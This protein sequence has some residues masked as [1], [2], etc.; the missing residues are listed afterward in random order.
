M[1]WFKR[2]VSKNSLSKEKEYIANQY[3]RYLPTA[4][5]YNDYAHIYDKLEK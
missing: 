1:S 5:F 4:I 3:S 2:R